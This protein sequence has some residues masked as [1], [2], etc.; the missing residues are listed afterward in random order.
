MN[1]EKLV[2]EVS[3][4]MVA[5]K[6]NHIYI[7]A[8]AIAVLLVLIWW[9]YTKYQDHEDVLHKATVMTEEMASKSNVLQNK[10]DNIN[11]QNAEMLA[12][13][14]KASQL[15]Q[16]APVA[17][18]T[19]M[20]NSPENAT[21]QVA[22]RINKNDITLPPKALEKT[23]T[24]LV[25]EHKLTAKEKADVD[26]ANE[27]KPPDQK[28]ND[29]YGVNVIKS[30]NYRNWYLGMGIGVHNGDTYIPLS[31]QRNF[32]KDSAIEVEAHVSKSASVTG[33]EIKY[34]KAV[35]KL[36]FFF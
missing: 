9:G 35:D 23:D 34:K 30:N 17:H 3:T 21:Q 20:S 8:A 13:V 27:N 15:G 11:K 24:T 19:V 28:V 25:L 31:V 14:V 32:S 12:A 22:D 18:F 10:F 4:G 1:T 6:K 29:I 26:K 2:D 7:V 36:F 33:G 16:V 5:V